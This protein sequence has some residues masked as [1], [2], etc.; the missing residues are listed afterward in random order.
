MTTYAVLRIGCEVE[1]VRCYS[2]Y[3]LY[4]GG[5]VLYCLVLYMHYIIHVS[6]ICPT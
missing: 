2:T 4:L 6:V 1:E 5:F 3:V